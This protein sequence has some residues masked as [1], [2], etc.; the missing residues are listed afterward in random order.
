MKALLALLVLFAAPV[1]AAQAPRFKVADVTVHES[2]G[3]VVM[4]VKKIGSSTSSSTLTYAESNVTAT[5]ADYTPT[6]GTVTFGPSDTVKI[7]S[8][9]VVVNSIVEPTKTFKVKLT[10][11]VNARCYDC[12][13]YVTI[14]DDS[15]AVTP[16]A[17]Q[18]CANGQVIL[19]SATCP[20]PAPTTK[21]CPDGSSI[22]V[23]DT[24]PVSTPSTSI[25]PV[26]ERAFDASP[27]VANIPSNF[28]TAITLQPSWGTGA[29]AQSDGDVVGAFRFLCNFSQLIYDDPIM[30]PAQAGQKKS[31]LHVFFGNT[32]ANGNST[33]ASLRASGGSTCGGDGNGHAPNRSAYW[34]PAMLDGVGH[35]VMPNLASVYYKRLPLSDPKCS[36]SN[37]QGEGNCVPLPNGLR[38]I[39]GFD[40]VSGTA[41]AGSF[42]WACVGQ[43]AI[44]W[45]SSDPAQDHYPSL[46]YAA[47]KCPSG[48]N[49]DGSHNEIV[50]VIAAPNCWDGVNLDSPDHR[51][52]MAYE[53]DTHAGYFRCPADHPY[54]VPAFKLSI[55]YTVDANLPTWKLSSDAMYSSLP[56]GSTLH[57]DWFGAW[58]NL[59]EKTWMDNCINKRLSCTGGD[60]GNGQQIKPSPSFTQIANPRLVPVPQ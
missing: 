27:G 31:H 23:A 12:T 1:Q 14:I 42:W 34:A 43:T 29:I 11:G 10:T 38:Y 45:N 16:P 46:A 57:S 36:L 48:V 47:T 8:I 3:T 32:A 39:F 17:T 15:T 51:A 40:M 13:A 4:T 20:T 60:L 58:D 35:V 7:F 24:C 41:P 59:V 30:F 5:P 22:P 33:F 6:T 25:G 49:P 21:F 53:Y 44:P 54:L 56:A 55:A 18:T 52:H 37:P 50:A 26:G 19:A 2:A 28:D 9:P